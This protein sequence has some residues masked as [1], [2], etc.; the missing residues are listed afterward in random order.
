RLLLVLF[1]EFARGIDVVLAAVHAAK[2]RRR[3]GRGH[4]ARTDAC[5][6]RGVLARAPRP[7]ARRSDP[8][9]IRLAPC[10]LRGCPLSCLPRS[11]SKYFN[12][13]FNILESRKV[14]IYFI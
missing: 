12:R 10:G 11:T 1:E 13:S 14:F 7:S 8:I 4:P 3:R 6:Q 2:V 9:R 5:A